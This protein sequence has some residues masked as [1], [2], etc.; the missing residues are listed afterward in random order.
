[1]TKKDTIYIDNQD[2]ITAIIGKVK[3]SS[4]SLVVLVPPK[5]STVFESIVNV[6]LLHKTSK[7]NKKQLVIVTENKKISALAGATSIPV[8]A[9]LKAKPQI[10]KVSGPS[11]EDEIEIDSSD[12]DADLHVQTAV[13]E[14]DD[15]HKE[16]DEQSKDASKDKAKE[17][18]TTSEEST[19][20]A[21]KSDKEA[22]KTTKASTAKKKTA[23]I[24]SFE[25]FR[26]R[27]FLIFGGVVALCALAWW[28]LIILPSATIELHAQ[29]SPIDTSLAF[30]A[31]ATRALD[32]LDAGIIAA[33]QSELQRTVSE[34][35]TPTGEREIGEAATGVVTITN[36]EDSTGFTF[37]AGST[38][39]HDASGREF[40]ADADTFVGGSN[41]SGGGTVC[42]ESGFA[43][44]A[45]TAIAP[46]TEYNVAS[47]SYTIEGLGQVFAD[48]TATSGGTSETLTIVS[49]SDVDNAIERILAR[50]DSSIIEEL[51]LG[52]GEGM[53]VL[54]DSFVKSASSPSASPAVDDEATSGQV[55]VTLNYSLL[56]IPSSS[57]N[58]FIDLSQAATLQ[59][60][61]TV[62]D[63]G[64]EAAELV[65]TNG[66]AANS[67]DYELT[68]RAFIGPKLDLD[69]I[70]EDI[71]GKRF[72]EAREILENIE[73]VNRAEIDF[74][75]FWVSNVPKSSK[76]TL[77]LVISERQ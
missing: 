35:F 27:L 66:G 22:T 52:I 62:I 40:T 48:G 47:G 70:K 7:D 50:D 59:D 60:N 18:D 19:Q 75:P 46:G 49:Q 29:T 17:A 13:G 56:A 55:S 6:K 30:T 57:L 15:A 77:D 72:S 67:M 14:L 51:R 64:F 65:L 63:N 16:K 38:L 33:T 45:V 58:D 41:F 74:S 25:T 61:Q 10:P 69:S 73:G 21:K 23:K 44:V 43:N 54:E 36:C 11:I 9:T 20:S 1:M 71:A 39:I 26:T 12:E 2:D 53:L 32:D 37:L 4:G 24:P 34:E 42:D 3:K 8:A 68:T 28:A 76:T 31:D 5:R